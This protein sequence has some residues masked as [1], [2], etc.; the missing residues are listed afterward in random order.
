MHKPKTTRR[1][2]DRETADEAPPPEASATPTEPVAKLPP[3]RAEPVS[4]PAPTK[5]SSDTRL[6]TDDLM[7]IAE[8][9]A[10]ELA[11]LMEGT[12]PTA[13]IAIGERVKGRVTRVGASDLFVEVGGKS[14]ATLDRSEL[15]EAVVGDE[16]EAMV[17]SADDQGIR[18]SLRLSG[19]AA[20]EHLEDALETGVPVQGVV[21]SRNK[22]GYTVAIGSVMAFC[23][24]SR[25]SRIQDVDPDGYLGQTLDFRVIE[26]DDKVVVDR[27]VLQ[28]EAAE[29]KATELWATLEVGQ[30]LRGTV[31]NVQPF[32]VFVDL[33]GVDGLVP[34]RELVGSDPAVGT[35]LE[36]RVIEI[37]RQAKRLTL[38]AR[39]PANDPWNLVGTEFHTGGVYPGT[40]VKVAAFGAFVELADG[41]QGLVHTSRM[42]GGLPKPGSSI[43]VKLLEIDR[44][45]QRLA[46]TPV[47]GDA[48]EARP[49]Q[50]VKG[51][52]AE[53]L[54]NGVVVQLDD[55]RTGWLAEREADLEPGTVLAQRFRKGKAIEARVVEDGDRRVQLSLK[56]DPAAANRAW[57][58]HA[59][60]AQGS[61]FGTLGD[62]LGGLKLPK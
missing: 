57:R 30:E 54:R 17:L 53:V 28:D 62:L 20:I 59:G 15:P 29:E 44:D 6:N 16:I 42:P 45:R 1:R 4:Q 33:G 49:G 47:S 38:S 58:Q 48:A 56:E 2:K 3:R 55:G 24:I 40:V 61:G 26:A 9:D 41:L 25:I 31:R 10:S 23:P 37:D 8:M 34:K 32:G 18:L 39:N 46:L 35:G 52:V 60:K 51:T 50:M 27:R 14:E 13:R 19:Q 7:A 43:T 5:P 12:V 11:A 21:K 36:V 22:G